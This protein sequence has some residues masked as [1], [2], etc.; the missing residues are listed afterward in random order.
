MGRDHLP[1]PMALDP[2]NLRCA[3]AGNDRVYALLFEKTD[4]R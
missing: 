2:V 3:I 1:P 4:G